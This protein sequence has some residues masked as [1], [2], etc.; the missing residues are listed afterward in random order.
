MDP[1]RQQL[2]R[3]LRQW[4]AAEK[5]S[6]NALKQVLDSM[7]RLDYLSDEHVGLLGTA[8]L[9]TEALSLS[10]TKLLRTHDA[11]FQDLT[12][13]QAE[14][15]SLADSMKELVEAEACDVI[16]VVGGHKDLTRDVL[17]LRSEIALRESL[18]QCLPELRD[19][20]EEERQRLW[21]VWTERP[22]SCEATRRLELILAGSHVARKR[23]EATQLLKLAGWTFALHLLNRLEHSVVVPDLVAWSAAQNRLAKQLAWRQ[24][25]AL[26]GEV[27]QR[28]LQ[29]DAVLTAV[30]INACR[31]RWQQACAI[32]ANATRRNLS[33]QVA[34]S[35]SILACGMATEWRQALAVLSEAKR[36]LNVTTYSCA[37][38]A[39]EKAAQ[40]QKALQL[41]R[42]A[43][44]QQV[45]PDLVLYSSVISATE[46]AGECIS[47]HFFRLSKV[48]S[49]PHLAVLSWA[50]AFQWVCSSRSHWSSECKSP[51]L[52]SGSTCLPRSCGWKPNL[53]QQPPCSAFA[54][55]AMLMAWALLLPAVLGEVCD[56]EDFDVAVKRED[57]SHQ[58]ER[59]E[60]LQ[61]S[62]GRSD[63][64]AGH[65]GP[66]HT[67]VVHH[68]PPGIRGGFG[69]GTTVVHHSSGYH[70]VYHPVYHPPVYHPYHPVYPAP[71][72]PYGYY[73]HGTTVAH[74]HGGPVHHGTTV[75][76]HSSG[77]VHHGTTVVHHSGGYR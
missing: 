41:L 55:L 65:H 18:L 24:A 33:S 51:I 60:L 38:S 68:N 53:P 61:R 28:R 59:L 57:P 50:L 5:L 48:Q 7:T 44:G 11:A 23:K 49:F 62:A 12:K 63:W 56:T 34:C 3:L 76:H 30:T 27:Q 67:T 32:L 20:G 69:H 43:E 14:M 70:P 66:G 52:K 35:S 74:H 1:R 16:K 42:Q 75:V 54:M 26:L 6:A 40:W 46:A 45:M 15:S 37:V 13:M 71:Y 9:N 22:F 2:W 58:P 10:R 36:C 64:V 31:D 4:E 39:M 19:A 25:V 21:L 29:V 77:P 17:L 47:M 72:H 8:G 73:H